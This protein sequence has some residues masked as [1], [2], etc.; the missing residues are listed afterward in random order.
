MTGEVI[1]MQTLTYN[2]LSGTIKSEGGL[3]NY[4]LS[5]RYIEVE[6]ILIRFI[7]IAFALN[8]VIGTFFMKKIY[9]D[10]IVNLNTVEASTI[11]PKIYT[12]LEE[13]ASQSLGKILEKFG[14]EGLTPMARHHVVRPLY[15]V[16]GRLI[17]LGSDNF[18]TFE[19]TDNQKAI[20]EFGRISGEYSKSAWPKVYKD[21]IHL[22]VMDNIGIYY[23]GNNEEII[24]ALEKNSTSF[25]LTPLF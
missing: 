7:M 20:E 14:E 25:P 10:G 12:Q 24:K 1:F 22:Y 8:I 2:S 11:A 5:P 9:L 6:K 18:E 17:T 19:Y 15:G 23:L 16:D 21:S 3:M 4:I 13:P